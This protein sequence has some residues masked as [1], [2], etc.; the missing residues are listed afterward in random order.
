M[1]DELTQEEIDREF[2]LYRTDPKMFWELTNK[3]VELHPDS[4]KAYF[5]RHQAWKRLG[6]LDLALDDLDRSLALEDHFVAQRAKG[7][8]LH[9]MGRYPEAIVCFDRC[10]QM[11]PG[12]WPGALG[13]LIRADCHARLGDEAAA[14]ADCDALPDDHWTPGMFNLPAGNKQEV[15]AELSHRAAAAR[16]QQR[17]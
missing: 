5:G 11:E 14:L 8:I 13:P 2:Q 6:R 12:E 7:G 3:R 17:D 10:E 9:A 4:A 16:A 1:N 15:A